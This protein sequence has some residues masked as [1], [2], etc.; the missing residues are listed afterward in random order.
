[1]RLIVLGYWGGHPAPGS[2]CAGYMV[3][4]GAT[5]I[6]LDCGSGVVAQMLT[7]YR[8]GEISAAVITHKHYDHSSDVGVLGYGL[9]VDRQ[10][11]R[12]DAPLA[13]YVPNDFQLDAPLDSQEDLDLKQ[14]DDGATLTVGGIRLRFARTNHPV[15]CHAVR[16]EAEGRSL[17]YT[18]D[19]AVSESVEALADKA[20]VFLCEASLYDG[21]EDTASAAGHLTARQ[22]GELAARAGVR[23][24][25]ITHYPQY[26]DKAALKVQAEE[27]FGRPVEVINETLQRFDV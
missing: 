20:D 22:A 15:E 19:T 26:G 23:R 9:L 18:G 25:I 27:G 11:G 1:M 12:R 16:L 21:Q 6:L 24:L 14:I 13:T 17:V 4:H 3:E 5:R 7:R 8:L 2:A 10:L